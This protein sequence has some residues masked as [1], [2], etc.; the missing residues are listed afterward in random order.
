MRYLLFAAVLALLMLVSAFLGNQNVRETRQKTTVNLE[1]RNALLEQTSRLRV[2]LLEAYISLNVFLLDPEL[3]NY[4]RKAEDN[5]KQTIEITD[6][7]KDNI[8]VKLKKET[9]LVETLESLLTTFKQESAA[10]ILT[11]LDVT[12]QY[13]SLAVG[14]EVMRP[15][16]TRFHNAITLAMS[17]LEDNQMLRKSPDIYQKFINA[18][19]LWSQMLSDF[20]LYLANRVGTF[21]ELSLPLQERSI[22]VLHAELQG[23]LQDLNRLSQQNRLGFELDSVLT[24]MHQSSVQWYEGFKEVKRIHHSGEW[25]VDSKIMKE[26]ITPVIEQISAL[27]SLFENKL[28]LAAA[29]DIYLTSE[30][31]RSQSHIVWLI[32]LSGLLFIIVM[33]IS[34][35]MLVFKPVSMVTRALKRE[36]LT[37]E[38]TDLPSVQSQ[39]MQDLISAFREMSTQV[40]S[41]QCALEHQATHDSLTSLPNR[42]L[43]YDRIDQELHRAK[44][45]RMSFCLMVIDL[46]HFKDVNDTVGHHIGDSLLIEVGNRFRGILRETDTVAR[47]GGDEFAILL[48]E[49]TEVNSFEIAKKL[50]Q[51]LDRPFLI[52][53]L[54]L[55]VYASIGLAMFPQQGDDAQTLLQHA[56][57]A[58]YEAKREGLPFTVYDEGIDEFSIR[59]L[60]LT[61]E[62]P[63][64][65][66]NNGLSLKYQPKINLHNNSI[67]GVEALLRWEHSE[68]GEVPPLTIV[69]IAEKTGLIRTLTEWVIDNSLKQCRQWAN[70]GLDLQVAVNISVHNLKDSQLVTFIKDTLK[71]Y[72]FPANI[73]SLEITESAM[74]RNPLHAI[75]NLTRLDELGLN[76]AIDDYGTGFSSLA[77]LKQFPVDE[78]KIDKTFVIDMLDHHDD[79][80]IVRSTIELA[81][82][83]GLRVVAEGVETAEASLWLK[84]MGCDIA[85]GYYYGMPLYHYEFEELMKQSISSA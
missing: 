51:T 28:S 8:W 19:H 46:D 43:L 82:N 34:N 7:L 80:M 30:T 47:L 61:N 56:D 38:P 52:K 6:S 14:S 85:Q 13:P 81:H 21:N 3:K 22:E 27:L 31:A 70:Q 62:L 54:Q 65:L 33:L 4:Q 59:R 32:A 83:L 44:D 68:F 48:P 57:I 77:Y 60:A 64:A 53:D 84:K 73:L 11:R 58:M 37:T 63:S 71:L 20:R 66:A 5:I 49:T 17:E 67:I 79:E 25:R 41:R 55:H 2:H 1:T 69:D 10:L 40:H 45:T 76:L 9:R 12:T 26:R 42:I 50:I 23:V 39:E 24:D 16:R 78:L 72:R 35:Q 36:A 29:E 74:M 15:N 18:R 75:E